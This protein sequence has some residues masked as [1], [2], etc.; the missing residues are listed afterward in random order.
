[1]INSNAQTIVQNLM[2]LMQKKGGDEYAGEKV[3][4]LQHMYQAAE[5]ARENG[6]SDKLVL[7]AFLHDVGHIMEELTEENGMDGWG[8]IDHEK[9][10]GQFLRNLGFSNE[11]AELVESHVMVKRYLTWKDKA[12]YDNLSEASKKTLEYQGGVMSNEEAL[13]FEKDPLLE[14]KIKLRQLDDQAKLEEWKVGSLDFY[15]DLMLGHLE[16]Q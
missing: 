3:T 7:A 6:Y 11:V 8:M 16:S 9:A 14:D 15:K 13:E 1:M 4:Q 10:G 12:Y 2:D 5:L